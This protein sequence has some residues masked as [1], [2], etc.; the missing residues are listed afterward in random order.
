[1]HE[2]SLAFRN[3][4]LKHGAKELRSYIRE[5]VNGDRPTVRPD[6]TRNP[7]HDPGERSGSLVRETSRTLFSSSPTL[8][9]G[10]EQCETVCIFAYLR[11]CLIARYET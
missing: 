4:Q 1:M 9:P 11:T 3:R 6:P 2:E 10:Y 5:E 8:F 7:N